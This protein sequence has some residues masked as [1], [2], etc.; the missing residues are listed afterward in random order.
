MTATVDSSCS[1]LIHDAIDGTRDPEASPFPLV[2][3]ELIASYLRP[4]LTSRSSPSPLFVP[5]LRLPLKDVHGGDAPFNVA[6]WGWVVTSD[7]YLL[8]ADREAELWRGGEKEHRVD[9]SRIHI[10]DTYSSPPRHIASIVHLDSLIAFTC[11][12]LINR[13]GHT[14]GGAARASTSTTALL[15]IQ[16]G[17]SFHWTNDVPHSPPQRLCAYELTFDLPTGEDEAPVLVDTKE[18]GGQRWQWRQ[19]W[20]SSQLEPHTKIVTLQVSPH[21]GCIYIM[22]DMDPSSSRSLNNSTTS[23]VSCWSRDGQLLWTTEIHTAGGYLA[24]SVHGD[25]AVQTVQQRTSGEYSDTVWF[26]N[27]SNSGGVGEYQAVLAAIEGMT[28]RLLFSKRFGHPS[29]IGPSDAVVRDLCSVCFDSETGLLLA[30]HHRR[31]QPSAD[32]LRV[33][34]VWT[35]RA[36]A[37]AGRLERVEQVAEFG[38]RITLRVCEAT[39]ACFVS[40]RGNGQQITFS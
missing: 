17:W 33:E 21:T 3:S 10:F 40:G 25:M 22:H 32:P 39:G 35:L 26:V 27:L 36:D 9:L 4:P 23:G 13:G 37:I 18:G 30:E 7:G 1:S 15:V 16:H 11:T 5:V 28:G 38:S 34:G 31:S 6:C 12:R 14:T 8:I 29:S 24:P 20:C 19:L 2:L